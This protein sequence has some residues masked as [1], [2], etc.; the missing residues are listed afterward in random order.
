MPMHIWR[1]YSCE[2]HRTYRWIVHCYVW[3]PQGLQLKDD[4]HNPG[5]DPIHLSGGLRKKRDWIIGI[6]ISYSYPID[7]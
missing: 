1:L 2:H 5:D 4:E 6:G 3:C 7:D